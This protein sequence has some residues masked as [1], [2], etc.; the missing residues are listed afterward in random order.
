MSKRGLATAL[1]AVFVAASALT[2]AAHA[3]EPGDVRVPVSK[4]T[5]ASGQSLYVD[6]DALKSA[7]PML[8][9]A[10][11][12]R[13][14]CANSMMDPPQVFL[15]YGPVAEAP[16]RGRLTWLQCGF[17]NRDDM[18]TLDGSLLCGKPNELSVGFADDPSRYFTT[19]E[20]DAGEASAIFDAFFAGR[21][22]YAPDILKPDLRQIRDISI[23]AESGR[24]NLHYG[25]RGCTNSL[26][27]EHAEGD[28]A[29]PFRATKAWM[30]CI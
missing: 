12:R 27:I 4:A 26:R 29:A 9:N 2:C 20:V 14:T 24:V 22:E 23:I 18:Q 3:D 11:A 10:G 16:H 8:V 25:D 21:I 19:Y 5:D 13:S 28:A 30:T 17:E 7:F 6:D 1:S 15:H